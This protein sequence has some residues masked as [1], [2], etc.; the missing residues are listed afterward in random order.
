MIQ[1]YIASL[2]PH[3]ALVYAKREIEH[4]PAV[5]DDPYLYAP[6]FRNIS[7]FIRYNSQFTA[8]SFIGHLRVAYLNKRALPNLS[9]W[10]DS[11]LFGASSCGNIL[12]LIK[13]EI[14]IFPKL[15]EAM[16]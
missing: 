13:I 12:K 6:V 8:S 10:S 7:I 1:R 15:S 9:L 14:V 16:N 2:P 5:D 11:I 4:A 3:E